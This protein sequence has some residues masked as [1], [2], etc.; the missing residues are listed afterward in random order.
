M[1]IINKLI[2]SAN[3]FIE[4]H[5][6]VKWIGLI[7]S[8]VSIL[9]FI[10]LFFPE[11]EIASV[12]PTN[13]YV[14]EGQNLILEITKVTES[15][16]GPV[17]G[18]D[19]FNDDEIIAKVTGKSNLSPVTFPEHSIVF[20]WRLGNDFETNWHLGRRRVAGN[21]RVASLPIEISGNTE[22]EFLV[23]G[24]TCEKK[25]S[26]GVTIVALVVSNESKDTK[27]KELT[28][29]NSGWGIETLPIDNAVKVSGTKVFHTK[30]YR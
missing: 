21:Y 4:K 15:S 1:T 16:R 14:L 9:A 12:T 8:I 2:K 11:S 20:F 28:R 27:I 6:S 30:K 13:N 5:S 18:H 24:I 23:G 29:D 10:F 17:W 3:D 25:Y 7:G 22:W 19:S 26:G